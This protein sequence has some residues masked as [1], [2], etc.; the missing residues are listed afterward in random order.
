[1]N[2]QFKSKSYSITNVSMNSNKTLHSKPIITSNNDM[3]Y[4]AGNET[5]TKKQIKV[6]GLEV[7]FLQYRRSFTTVNGIIANRNYKKGP[8]VTYK[9]TR[10]ASFKSNTYNTLFRRCVDTRTHLQHVVS[11]I[12][13]HSLTTCDKACLS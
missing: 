3:F 1:M 7:I 4:V 5:N 10:P 12:H 9:T 8:K 2:L 11:V 13:K 6:N